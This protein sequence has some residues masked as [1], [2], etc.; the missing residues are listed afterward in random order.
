MGTFK[1]KHKAGDKMY[2]YSSF[3]IS[4]G[5]DD[6]VGGLATIERIDVDERLGIDHFNAVMVSFKER[7]STK[8]NYKNLLEKQ[9]ELEKEFGNNIAHADPDIDTPWIE[10]RRHR[11]WECLE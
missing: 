5:S 3:Y 9:S 4:R 10:N 11:K 2:V 1:I 6:F 8:Y 7:G